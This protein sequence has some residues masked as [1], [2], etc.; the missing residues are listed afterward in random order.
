[1]RVTILGGVVLE[2]SDAQT[3]DLREQ[4]GVS[5]ICDTGMLTAAQAAERLSVSVDFV[6]EHATE[7]GG[8]KL[9]DGPKAPWRFDPVKLGPGVAD[10]TAVP[11]GTPARRRAPRRAESG[12]LLQSR[13]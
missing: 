10:S 5:Q 13:R 1:M 2:L 6:R 9:T 4:L 3:A 7:L 12:R 8:V 11:D